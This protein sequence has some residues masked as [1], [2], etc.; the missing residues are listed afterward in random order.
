M[1]PVGRWRDGGMNSFWIILSYLFFWCLLPFRE[2]FRAVFPTYIF[3]MVCLL[4]SLP[5]M[6][7][8][9]FESS[10][11]VGPIFL[12]G[13]GSVKFALLSELSEWVFYL[14]CSCQQ[15]KETVQQPLKTTTVI[16]PNHPNK[17]I[18]QVYVQCILGET[19]TSSL[20]HSLALKHYDRGN[21]LAPAGPTSV[22]I[23]APV[24]N[25]STAQVQL[26]SGRQI[27]R[28]MRGDRLRLDQSTSGFRIRWT[29]KPW[30]QRSSNTATVMEGK[31]G[32]YKR[33]TKAVT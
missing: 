15:S 33:H 7:V 29:L 17:F 6:C 2:T 25:G 11:G 8:F 1:N 16:R 24:S 18:S 9:C 20:L 5:L 14:C 4:C 23:S 31:S 26:S 10:E 30:T 19:D 28:V 32:P 13:G 27:V 22:N 21:G 3:F 12:V